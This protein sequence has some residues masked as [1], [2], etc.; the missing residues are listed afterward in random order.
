MRRVLHAKL[1]RIRK[2]C[3]L[4]EKTK[5]GKIRFMYVISAHH[6]PVASRSCVGF[7]VGTFSV[8]FAIDP[9]R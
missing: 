6:L 7:L 3:G 1:Y 5:G 9:L 8:P 2:Q 4:L